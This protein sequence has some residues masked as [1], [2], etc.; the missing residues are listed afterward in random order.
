MERSSSLYPGPGSLIIVQVS[1]LLARLGPYGCCDDAA[2]PL[3]RCGALRPAR[4]SSAY[5][6]NIQPLFRTA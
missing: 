6:M 2:S 1:L 4:P 5:L 3:F